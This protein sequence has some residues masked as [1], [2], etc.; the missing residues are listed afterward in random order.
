MNMGIKPKID[1]VYDLMVGLCDTNHFPELG[2]LITDEYAEGRKCDRLYT[3][4]YDARSRIYERLGEELDE[5]TIDDM[6]HIFDSFSLIT[7]YL[8]KK[9]FQYGA[10]YGTLIE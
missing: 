4:A 1:D 3:D 10:Q 9:M 5:D 2:A 6:E 8:C 7:R